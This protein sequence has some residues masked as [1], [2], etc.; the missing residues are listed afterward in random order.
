M[1]DFPLDSIQTLATVERLLRAQGNVEAAEIIKKSKGEFEHTGYDN[2]D[3]GTD[4]FT[5]YLFVTA[6]E[7]AELGEKLSSL[8]DAINKSLGSLLK[9]VSNTWIKV[10]I[11]PKLEGPITLSNGNGDIP[12]YVRQNILDGLKI[13]KVKWWGELN[14]T[15][16]LNRIYNLKS[17]PS[18]DSRFKN[19]EEDIW[20]HTQNNED[21]E[22]DWV[23]TDSRFKLLDGEPEIFIK[24]ISELVHPV[25][26]P[27]TTEVKKLVNHF[28]DQLRPTGWELLEKEKIAG[29]P[30]YEG[31]FHSS[32][33]ILDPDTEDSIVSEYEVLVGIRYPTPSI[34]A[35]YPDK[36][37]IYIYPSKD[38]WNDFSYKT[39]FKMIVFEKNAQTFHCDFRLAFLD[40]KNKPSKVIE[41][42]LN[43][44]DY[45][46]ASNL[47]LFFTMQIDMKNYRKVI[48]HF[49]Q[50]S[51]SFL[52]HIN[53]LVATK[54]IR[55]NPEWY[56]RAIESDEFNLSFVRNA[57]GYFAFINADSILNGLEHERI[58]SISKELNLQFQLPAFANKHKFSFKFLEDD[59]LEDRIA[60]LIGK[61]GVGK[62]QTLN[63]VVSSLLQADTDTLNDEQSDRIKINKVVGIA[64]PGETKYTFPAPL[65]DAKI[66][67]K[68]LLL[69][70]SDTQASNEALGS[71]LVQIAR[72]EEYI[73]GS[74]RWTI[75]QNSLKGIIELERVALPTRK[76]FRGTAEYDNYV[77]LKHIYHSGGEEKTLRACQRVDPN[78]NPI[79]F[80]ESGPVPLS[81]GQ[82]TF[83]GI[84]ASIC[85]HIENGTLLLLDEPEIHLHPNMI[86]KLVE[87]LNQ[88]LKTTGSL[89]IIAT[90]SV[91]FVR[92][93]PRTQVF[94][95]RETASK[96]IE[97]QNPRL[98]TIGA[99][100]GAISNYIFA[101]E[102]SGSLLERIYESINKLPIELKKPRLLSLEPELPSEAIT[103]LA[104]RLEIEL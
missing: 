40:Q 93:V 92:E 39:F 97:V 42:T 43:G 30:R 16:F 88:F 25:V 28:N 72:G 71:I 29:H 58:D 18:E 83:I 94:I 52:S 20:Q 69:G 9:Q 19:A 55:P 41:S 81:S 32:R 73:A 56:E 17:L 46:V 103:H 82:L 7:Y 91:Y 102:G 87:L 26:R 57:D 61:N 100:I 8:E 49:K 35:S 53:D 79:Y 22:S 51:I 60:I 5:L 86:T 62:S 78:S 34:T 85:L 13:E 11:L 50:K 48:T 70:R 21:W 36:T 68:R 66:P 76:S 75:L 14:D 101:D 77:L 15:A 12:R 95:I 99:E 27:D 38:G 84:A 44:S 23:Y 64:A 3:G 67:Y 6:E 1:T 45:T 37:V 54:Q 10:E 24:F 47:P 80:S 90:H 31:I 2:W 96:V 59:L 89:A 104:Y 65:D 63:R 33:E 74:D 98:K 4:I